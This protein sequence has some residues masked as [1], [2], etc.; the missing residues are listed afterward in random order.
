[1]THDTLILPGSLAW[2]FAMDD[3]PPPPGWRQEADRTN[4]EMA[5]IG[6]PGGHGLLQA[7]T[8]ARYWEYIHDGEADQR[9]DEIEAD[10][11]VIW[12]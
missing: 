8:L 4:G 7:V 3:L 10:D 5:L 6:L 9:Q 12:I 2:R 11:G 1:M